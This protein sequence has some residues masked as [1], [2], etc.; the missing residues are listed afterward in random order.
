M[1]LSSRAPVNPQDDDDDDSMLLQ[2]SNSPSNSQSPSPSTSD[3]DL[4]M[5]D[6]VN[7][8]F[9]QQ[10][11]PLVPHTSTQHRTRSHREDEHSKACMC[12]GGLQAFLYHWL[13]VPIQKYPT[14]IL[15]GFLLIL[16]AS[17]ALDTQIQP[18]TKP[19]AFFKES[20]NLQQL[21]YLKYNMSSDKLNVND[22][23]YEL[24]GASI[25]QSNNADN[26]TTEPTT[27][28]KETNGLKSST[29][30]P[31]RATAVKPG[32]RPK[33]SI[34]KQHFSFA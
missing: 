32:P 9:A 17:I 2:L 28:P 8:T 23:A 21:L 10:M 14:A 20:T 25:K 29:P 11:T 22:L 12:G 6:D 15:V 5:F 16:G 7:S 18:S 27:K 13:G 3:T 31:T 19:P 26:P 24:A 4:A 34:L 33:T 1:E 30:I